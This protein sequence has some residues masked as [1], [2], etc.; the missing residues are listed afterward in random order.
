MIYEHRHDRMVLFTEGSYSDQAATW[1]DQLWVKKSGTFLGHACS[2]VFVQVV[3][4]D[5]IW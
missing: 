4:V 3:V 2:H 5:S 1:T